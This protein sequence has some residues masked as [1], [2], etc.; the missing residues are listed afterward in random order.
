MVGQQEKVPRQVCE[1]KCCVL[2]N[3]NRV[4]LGSDEGA[5][6]A[7]QTTEEVAD[8]L[9]NGEET[10]D[11]AP[12]EDE[13]TEVAPEVS[14]HSDVLDFQ[15]PKLC[16]AFSW[17][18]TLEATMLIISSQAETETL[19]PVDL[20]ILKGKTVNKLGKITDTDV[21]YSLFTSH[22]R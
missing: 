13:L 5:Q 22:T 4:Q 17:H 9:P 2:N 8:K 18:T 3:A 20:S 12:K 21:C 1:K 6:V 19:E 15:P 14:N 7:E 10:S 11:K 16:S